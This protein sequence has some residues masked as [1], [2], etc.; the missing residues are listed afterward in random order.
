MKPGFNEIVR[1]IRFACL[2]LPALDARDLFAVQL[3]QL[4]STADVLAAYPS[5]D[6]ERAEFV[7]K[8]ADRAHMVARILPLLTATE[9]PSWQRIE[10]LNII[11][12]VE[13]CRDDFGFPPALEELLFE[14]RID[15]AEHVGPSFDTKELLE[16]A[17]LEPATSRLQSTPRPW[18]AGRQP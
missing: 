10:M 18:Y 3:E 2:Q 9:R 4:G 15:L 11:D 14:A 8:A 5:P 17:G 7:R 1:S 6:A 12:A 16:T 13:I